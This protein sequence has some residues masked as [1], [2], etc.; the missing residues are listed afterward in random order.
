MKKCLCRQFLVEYLYSRGSVQCP[1]RSCSVI[2]RAK[3]PLCRSTIG[4]GLCS[5][6]PGDCI[7]AEAQV[8]CP[9]RNVHSSSQITLSPVNYS[10]MHIFRLCAN[11]SKR[12]MQCQAS[13]ERGSSSLL[14]FLRVSGCRDNLVPTRCR[15][16]IPP[17]TRELPVGCY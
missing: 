2:F 8:A 3:K 12:Y 4:L 14:R 17:E 7:L 10:S 15:S 13:E 9:R 1:R 6:R 16:F 5:S 11:P